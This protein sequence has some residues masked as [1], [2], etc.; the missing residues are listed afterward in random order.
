MNTLW[1]AIVMLTPHIF[2]THQKACEAATPGQIVSKKWVYKLTP[3]VTA[4]S[5]CLEVTEWG[6]GQASRREEWMKDCRQDPDGWGCYP[7]S[8]AKLQVFECVPT[9][10]YS[11]EPSEGRK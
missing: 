7:L 6:A 4:E 1:I 11:V 3:A 8:K 9:P 10:S 2:E 5:C